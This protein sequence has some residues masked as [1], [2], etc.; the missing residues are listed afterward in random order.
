MNL[1][2]AQLETI[3]TTGATLLLGTAGTGKTTALQHRL[4]HLLQEGEPA[5][6]VLILVA[7]P[8]HKEPFVEFI[9]NA[10][11][12]AI[13]D[14]KVVHYV[15]L[16]REMGELFWPL[17]A[18]EAGF[19]QAYKPPT[20]LGYDLAQLL[21]WEIVTPMLDAGHFADL[22]LRP[23]Q[24]VSQLLDNLNRSA[25]NGHNLDGAFERQ[26][27]AWGGDAEHI[28]HLRDAE[29]AARR[30]RAICYENNLLDMSL[31]VDVF[32]RHVIGHPEFSRYFSERF[33][34]M[35]V[36]NVEEQTAAGHNFV[37]S[38]IDYTVSTTIAYDLGGGY[39][40]F[41][42]ADATDQYLNHYQHVCRTIEF[43]ERH[44]DQQGIYHVAEVVDR[45]LF[46][47]EAEHPNT[48][49]ARTAILDWVHGRY[50]RE[51]ISR[52]PAAINDLMEQHELAPR[53]IA[54]VIPYLDGALRYKLTEALAEAGIPYQL[55]RRRA[56]PREEPRVRAWIT[57]LALAHPDWNIYPTEYD[58]A[59][60]LTLS[61]HGLDPARAA[62]ITR[63]LYQPN[64][65]SLRDPAELSAEQ[66]DRIGA[67]TVALVA[68]LRDW[69][70]ANG[71]AGEYQPLDFFVHRLFTELLSQR[72][73]RPEPDV[74][75]AAVSDWLVRTATR[76]RES[77]GP[78]G[79]SDARAIGRAFIQGINNGL[80]SAN[81]PDLGEPPDP[82]GVLITTVYSFLLSE[83]KVPVQVW[84]ETA[85]TGWWDMPRQP[86]SNTFVLAQSWDPDDIWTMEDDVRIRNAL[87]SRIVRG[88]TSRCELG[89]VLA[90]SD[91]DRRGVRQDGPLWR[92]LL[93]L[94]DL[95]PA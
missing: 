57:W 26:I 35:L 41:L 58:V 65:P 88:L 27:S 94:L 20:W 87:L 16:A 49:T 44:V 8:Y 24:I 81:P 6:T 23:Q 56:T 19:R 21:M 2:Q 28:R 46:G 89:I 10:G 86:L 79:L 53:E 31:V 25:L 67:E 45:Y 34:H 62:L 85:A 90:T 59:E 39:K 13:A 92:A 55:A 70:A 60:A 74:Q 95:E 29:M 17:V 3:E 4:L 50:R 52:L 83:K 78:M 71:S 82:N 33:R 36:D 63:S 42:A 54:I 61:I 91:L 66:V 48:A 77:A 22:R 68:E 75:G 76:L 18:R 69:L 11:V 32:N 38:S 9:H 37:T 7:E 73:F 1:T 93:P 80:V 12:A 40:T 72:A 14:L 5:Y 43:T 30:F 47:A 64:F 84:L 15:G 51:M